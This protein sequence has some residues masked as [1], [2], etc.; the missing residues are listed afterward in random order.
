MSSNRCIPSNSLQS[1]TMPFLM[2]YKPLEM[3]FLPILFSACFYAAD[4]WLLFNLPFGMTKLSLFLQSFLTIALVAPIVA[5]W[6]ISRHGAFVLSADKQGIYYKKLDDNNQMVFIGWEYI[7]NIHINEAG[8]KTLLIETHYN[9]F[10][11]E[12]LALPCN[13]SIYF[14]DPGNICL[15]F[16]ASFSFKADHILTS[17]NQLRRQH[18]IKKAQHHL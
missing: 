15:E 11:Q 2:A 8:K 1:H 3:L 14:L 4:L 12:K 18:F 6:A 7:N 13:G 5:F 10:K 17:L 16:N 9:K